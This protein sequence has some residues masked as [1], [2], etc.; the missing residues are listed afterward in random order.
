M[1]SFPLQS[2]PMD[3]KLR[4][5]V[6][7]RDKAAMTKGVI[8]ATPAPRQLQDSDGNVYH[9]DSSILLRYSSLG[10]DRTFPEEFY[11]VEK[12][13]HDALLRRDIATDTSNGAL[14]CYPFFNKTSKPGRSPHRSRRMPNGVKADAVRLKMIYLHSKQRRIKGPKRTKKR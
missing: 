12:C 8:K 3:K 14:G 5:S 9:T 7:S 13:G 10:S 1:P 4:S 11:I 2:W 6:I